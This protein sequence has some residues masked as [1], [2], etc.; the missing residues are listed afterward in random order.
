MSHILIYKYVNL[1]ENKYISIYIK[2]AKEK[3]VKVKLCEFM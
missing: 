3:K 2:E 1:Y